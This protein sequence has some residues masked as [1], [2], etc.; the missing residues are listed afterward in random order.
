MEVFVAVVDLGSLTAAANKMGI[1]APMVGKHLRALEA[2]L[3]AAV[4]VR[5]TRRQSLSEIGRAYYERCKVI[6]DEVRMADSGAA[7]LRQK[8]RGRLR[9]S[10]PV[11]FGSLRFAPALVDYMNA[12]A[13]VSVELI[14][15]DRVVD[16]IEDGFDAAIRIG[17]LGDS[18]LVARPLAS[19]SMMIA[20]TP[21]YLSRHGIPVTPADL[22]QHN[23]LGF[24]HWRHSGGWKLGR[25]H[26]DDVQ[27]QF[28]CNHGPALRMV[29][30]QSLGLVMQPKILLEDDVA[31][32]RLVA[33]LNKYIP[34]P[35]PVHLVYPKDKQQLP[36]V[37]TLISFIVDRF[38]ATL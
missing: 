12:H 25:R 13:E 14:L 35:S 8:P 30:L 18:N 5:S 29:A 2:H 3:G 1:S 22:A 19:Y 31:A 26:I 20:A 28:E 38:S 7:V 15:N 23:C 32:G 11:S 37:K 17:N 27:R 9:I 10:A 36:K 34:P 21:E 6:L 4:L 16:L 24:T 33:L